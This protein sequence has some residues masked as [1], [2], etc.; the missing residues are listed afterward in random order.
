MILLISVLWFKN[1]YI[2]LHILYILI[3]QKWIIVVDFCP[4]YNWPLTRIKK[5]WKQIKR[6]IVL[7]EW[8]VKKSNNF[9]VKDHLPLDTKINGNKSA[10]ALEY[11]FHKYLARHRWKSWVS[12]LF[13]FT[14]QLPRAM[15]LGWYKGSS[16]FWNRA[17]LT[18][19]TRMT[20]NIS[21]LLPVSLLLVMICPV[22]S[23]EVSVP[24][25]ESALLQLHSRKLKHSLLL[26][27]YLCCTCIY[28]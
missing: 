28:V 7:L 24:Q 15:C 23:S 17:S 20:S 19:E 14:R 13:S 6:I 4:L 9:P 12:L 2:F 27:E 21:F 10:F 5:W 11:Y 25:D 8:T 26:C 16:L 18:P 22:L 1:L 3:Y